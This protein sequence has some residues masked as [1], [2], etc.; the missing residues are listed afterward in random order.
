MVSGPKASPCHGEH[1]RVQRLS[2]RVRECFTLVH[3]FDLKEGERYR[4]VGAR[5]RDFSAAAQKVLREYNAQNSWTGF[6][7]SA[8]W[9]N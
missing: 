1:I 2:C 8:V 7:D 4:N 5:S 6:S 3:R 9:T